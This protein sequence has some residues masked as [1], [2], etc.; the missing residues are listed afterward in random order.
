MGGAFVGLD[1]IIEDRISN[2]SMGIGANI[3]TDEE[4]LSSLENIF[5]R[6]EP[7]DLSRYG[8]IPE[9]VGRLPVMAVLD[10][11]DEKALIQILIQ[12]KNALVKQYQKLF[13]MDGTELIF[14]KKALEA[15]AKQAI[16][17]KTGAR[18]LRNVLE[19]VML[20][21]MYENPSFESKSSKKCV[22]TQKAVLKK[23]KPEIK[24]QPKK[25]ESSSSVKQEKLRSA[26]ES[27][28]IA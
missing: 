23:E 2:K 6:V 26:E 28:K 11:L 4:K 1:H 13:H 12:P 14:E 19:E 22:I 8:L 9:F 24:I 27:E 10:A 25:Q 17:K 5:K 20:D 21:L 18:G 16:V 3:K 15:I 7:S